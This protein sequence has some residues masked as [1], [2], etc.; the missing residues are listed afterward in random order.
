MSQRMKLEPLHLKGIEKCMQKQTD[1][2][3][4]LGLPCGLDP[5]D[6]DKQT[7]SLQKNIVSYLWL[8]QAAGIINLS[9]EQVKF[10]F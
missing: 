9:T 3:L 5:Y 10:L 7:L 4:L 6:I 8:K 2:C 1:Y